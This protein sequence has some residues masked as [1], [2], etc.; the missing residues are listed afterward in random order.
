MKLDAANELGHLLYDKVVYA[1]KSE[2]V[3][4][5]ELERKSVLVL[6]IKMLPF[7]VFY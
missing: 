6:D 3:A 5:E 2:E 4:F 1:M 7:A